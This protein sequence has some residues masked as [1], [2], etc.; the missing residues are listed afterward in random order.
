VQH[1]P[2]GR[3]NINRM[4]NEITSEKNNGR[5][6]LIL[7]SIFAVLAFVYCYIAYT[8]FGYDDEYFNIRVVSENGLT[9]LIKLIQTSDIHPPLSYIIN[10]LLF[11]LLHSWALVRVFSALL[12]LC[13]LLLLVRKTKGFTN[14][15]LVILLLGLNPTVL[16]WCTG[17][18]WY[19]Y[20]ASLILLLHVVPDW[21]KKGYWWYFFALFLVFC[22]L[23][24]AGCILFLPYFIFYWLKDQHSLKVKIKR[25]ILPALS[26]GALYSYQLFIFLTVHTKTK[27]SADNEQVFD[28]K[29]SLLSFVSSGFSNQG[30]FPLSIAGIV[31]ILGSSILFIASIIY[32][33]DTLKKKNWVVF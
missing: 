7:L 30:V 16:L 31:S 33:K 22:Y 15:L 27:L 24:Y 12:Y 19:A 26:F 25:I 6:K 17:I 5:Q 32:Y 14:R 20:A 8:S 29:T 28:I 4:H 9:D 2:I 1:Y 11:N 3:S 21:T 10:Y 23:G 18:R 13:A